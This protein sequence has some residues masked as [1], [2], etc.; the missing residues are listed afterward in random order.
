MIPRS[1]QVTAL[2]LR[3][4]T[5]LT[6]VLLLWPG[7]AL[8]LAPGQDWQQIS[9]EH[10][11]VYFPQR[12]ESF[13][14]RV[15]RV[16]DEAH[17]LIQE[18][19][20]ASPRDRVHI[21]VEDEGDSANGWALTVPYNTIHVYAAPPSDLST[22]G[23]SDDWLRMLIIHEYTHIVHLDTVSGVPALVQQVIGKQWSPNQVQP[24]WFVEGLAILAESRLTSG[25][26][27]RSSL[28]QMFLRSAAL[29]GKL[30]DLASLSNNTR[31]FPHGAAPYI[32]GGHFVDYLARRYGEK[33]FAQISQ[34]YGRQVL[35]FGLN[36]ASQGVFDQSYDQLYQDFLVEIRANADN[37]LARL[38]ALGPDLSQQI[39]D[40][41]ETL[42]LPRWD[43]QGR[44]IYFAAPADDSPGLY[45]WSRDGQSNQRLREVQGFAGMDFLPDG[46]LL[47]SQGEVFDNHYRF[48]DLYIFDLE[49][50]QQQRLTFGLRAS[51]PSV[52]PDG[53]RALFVRRDGERCA[54]SQIDFDNATLSDIRSFDD[55]SQFYSPDFNP[56]G[57]HAV[58]SLWRPG[59]DRDLWLIDLHS[60]QLSQLTA[61]RALDMQPQFSNDGRSLVFCS[62]RDKVFH[63]YRMDLGDG[64]VV[65]LSN[66][67]TGAFDPLLS[68]DEKQLYFVAYT[69]QGYALFH[70]AQ[71]DFLGLLADPSYSRPWPADP[72]V[73]WQGPA[74]SYNP[75]P[76][77]GP[78]TWTP[79]FSSGSSGAPLLGL[80]LNGEDAVGQHRWN[81]Q[82]RWETGSPRLEADLAYAFS[83]LA[84]PIQVS[85][86]RVD[87]LRDLRIDPE[88]PRQQLRDRGLDA[89][90]LA[91]WPLRRWYRSLS[92]ATGY[93]L[94]WREPSGAALVPDQR[95]PYLPWTGRSA[96]LRLVANYSDLRRFARSISIERGVFISSSMRLAQPWIGSE[97]SFFEI[98]GE[99]RSYLPVPGLPG[100]VVALKLQAGQAWGP[101]D[102]RRLYVVGGIPWRSPID[103]VL[104]GIPSSYAQLRGYPANTFAGDGMLTFN[105]EYRWP[106]WQQGW[107]LSTLPVYV[108]QLDAAVFWDQGGAFWEQIRTQDL[109]HRGLGVELRAHLILGFMLPFTLHAGLA[110]GFDDGGEMLLPYLSA[111]AS[112]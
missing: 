87:Q 46:R 13:A 20:Q 96:A 27:V 110:H 3:W 61:D 112:Y 25:G 2:L 33:S 1:H 35:P 101:R 92:L 91:L 103:Q 98:N 9:S 76:T 10:C 64:R 29:E 83:D 71:H 65:Q 18:F 24:R 37:T 15:A 77:L 52:S 28:Q 60:G 39:S 36:R 42:R 107:G 94:R 7:V 54:L 86:S 85:F 41:A 100:H 84:W 104:I 48:H 19:L 93:D 81:G 75:L 53:R 109:L 5:G 8:A 89:G 6:W 31:N 49:Q 67:V 105:L 38:R 32:Y 88:A 44:L 95:R 102:Q 56:D 108:E 21:V 30:W 70:L 62:D 12:L 26:R 111:G 17:V 34:R 73:A 106:I 14:R 97:N 55:G 99:I 72:A 23:D 78:K 11:D 4:V 43:K 68:D 45:R 82:L 51:E 50:G 47:I 40:V 63:I 57:Q 22:L 59:G 69:A 58:V 90:F 80:S 79:I 66:K 74:Q 16:G